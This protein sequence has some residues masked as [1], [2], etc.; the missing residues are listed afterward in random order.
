MNYDLVIIGAGPGGLALAHCCSY[1]KLNIL[2]IDKESS[3]GGCHRVRRVKVND[4]YLMTEHGPRVYMNSFLNFI[5]LL[6]DMNYKFTDLFTISKIQTTD[7]INQLLLKIININES[8]NLSY[9]YLKF[10]FNNNYGNNIT[11]KEYMN[12]NNFSQKTFDILDRMCVSSDGADSS[13]YTLNRFFELAN[14]NSL[15]KFYQPK[16]PNDIGLFKIWKE[17]LEQ[18]NVKFMLNTEVINISNNYIIINNQPL[19][20]RHDQA[21]RNEK[22]YGNKFIFAIPAI[23]LTNFL[24]KIPL[25]QNNKNLFGNINELIIWSEDNKYLTYI[26]II[27]HWN[28]KLTLPIKMPIAYGPWYVINIIISDYMTFN[29]KTSQTVI[30]CAIAKNNTINPNINKTANECNKEELIKETFKILCEIYENKLPPY[31]EA[32]ISSGNYYENNKWN[33]IDNSFILSN[34]GYNL[35]YQ[36]KIYNNFYN[37]GVHNGNSNYKLTTIESTIE[38]AINLA[39]IFYPKLKDIYKLKKMIELNKILIIIIIIIILLLYILLLY[40]LKKF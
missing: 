1:L 17:F 25:E 29:E 33:D 21:G 34:N 7:I 27:Y 35:N 13:K 15:Y 31:T 40:K 6:N 10:L 11:M 3:I 16:K 26:S 14:Q 5:M 8:I 12:N 23:N 4:E 9:N 2:V 20:Q 39:H 18:R 37:L 28:I 22:I 30:S 38:N 24:N 32:L 19:Q 36:S